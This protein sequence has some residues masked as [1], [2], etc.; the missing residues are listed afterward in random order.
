M[1]MKQIEEIVNKFGGKLTDE[2][3]FYLW[4]RWRRSVRYDAAKEWQESVWPFLEYAVANGFQLG[5]CVLRYDSAVPYSPDN[6][7][8]DRGRADNKVREPKGEDI[9]TEYQ[10]LAERWNKSVY[11]PNREIVKSYKLRHGI[12]D[13]PK[14]IAGTQAAESVGCKWRYE[15][16]CTNASCPVRADFCPVVDYPGVCRFEESESTQEPM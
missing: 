7:F 10:R 1:S 12:M 5:M 6:C 15:E 13:A 3:A 8:F 2:E 9:R 16:V 14:P 4:D 11:E